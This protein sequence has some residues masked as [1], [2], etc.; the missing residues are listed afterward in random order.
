MAEAVNRLPF[1][2]EARV[3]S[4][5]SPYGTFGGGW[6][7]DRFF[8]GYNR[9]F[10]QCIV[11]TLKS[12]TM[13][14][15]DSVIEFNSSVCLYK[16]N[17]DRNHL[18]GFKWFCFEVVSCRTHVILY[19]ERHSCVTAHVS[20]LKSPLSR[21]GTVCRRQRRP[22]CHYH[23]PSCILHHITL[24][25]IPSQIKWLDNERPIGPFNLC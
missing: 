2:A 13:L 6:H 7:W 25:S 22:V 18:A 14:A 17:C 20:S 9:F 24:I 3:R 15:V 19:L 21:E 8:F 4:Q 12:S 11:V 10:H 23:A 16:Q 5:A 1:N